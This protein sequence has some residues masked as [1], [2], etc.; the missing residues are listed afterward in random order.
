M[1]LTFTSPDV[2]LSP[3]NIVFNESHLFNSIHNISQN[4]VCELNYPI[5][6][7]NSRYGEF[8][9]SLETCGVVKTEIETYHKLSETDI[10][11]FK[12]NVFKVIDNRNSILNIYHHHQTEDALMEKLKIITLSI[13]ESVT[14]NEVDYFRRG[15]KK[16]LGL[17]AGLT[18]AGDDFVYGLLAVWK[19]FGGG[20]IFKKE[21][22]TLLVENKNETG[23]I[24]YNM[25]NAL[26]KN[27][28]YLPLKNLFRQINSGKEYTRELSEIASFGA[29]SG[30]DMIAGVLFGLENQEY[31]IEA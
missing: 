31:K 19:T 4:S 21:L 1:L 7:F 14:A 23:I 13:Q 3:T 27:H 29:T 15:V 10:E 9:V 8:S 18:P 12:S 16:L 30:A 6:S 17:G 20:G 5:L 22:E 28:I 25:L 24:S 2:Q 11:L 26:I